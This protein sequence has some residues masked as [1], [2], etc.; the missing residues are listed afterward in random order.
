MKQAR[1]SFQPQLMRSAALFARVILVLG[2]LFSCSGQET[3][4]K[5]LRQR[6][7]SYV[8]NGSLDAEQVNKMGGTPEFRYLNR[9]DQWTQLNNVSWNSQ[10]GEFRFV[11]TADE[12]RPSPEVESAPQPGLKEILSFGK[13]TEQQSGRVPAVAV[14][15]LGVITRSTN[16]DGPLS[17][18]LSAQSSIEISLERQIS[19]NQVMDL[20][21]MELV[22]ARSLKLSLQ[23]HTGQE[24]TTGSLSP[25]PLSQQLLES[26]LDPWSQ[27]SLAPASFN[28]DDSGIYRV[29][30]LLKEIPEFALYLRT[31]DGCHFI[32][33]SLSIDEI[34]EA[35]TLSFPKC[36]TETKDPL[37][38]SDEKWVADFATDT[39]FR[40]PAPEVKTEFRP[41]PFLYT[42]SRKVNIQLWS[43]N[44]SLLLPFVVEVFS[45]DDT[46]GTPVSQLS[47][48]F[49]Q[50]ELR[51]ELPRAFLNSFGESSATGRFSIRIRRNQ[52]ISTFLLLRGHFQDIEPDV[53]STEILN[54]VSSAEAEGT[55]LL[56]GRDPEILV[57]SPFCE[58]QD[59]SL[60]AARKIG[61]S[62]KPQ[63]DE[64]SIF[65]QH[66]S[67]EGEPL[68][69]PLQSLLKAANLGPGSVGR[70]QTL[71][72]A[73]EDEF[74]SRS[75]DD[76][77]ENRNTRS[78]YLDY[79]IPDL[80]LSPLSFGLAIG[81]TAVGNSSQSTEECIFGY[82]DCRPTLDNPSLATTQWSLRS[83]EMIFRFRSKLDCSTL[84]SE[85]DGPAAEAHAVSSYSLR[86]LTTDP[87]PQPSLDSFTTC[88]SDLVI[89]PMS[90]DSLP[91]SEDEPLLYELFV[92]DPAGHISN[93]Q[94]LEIPPCQNSTSGDTICWLL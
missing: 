42:N 18:I 49:F 14:A 33:P 75:A 35:L 29:E 79:G 62:L 10:T 60:R 55:P 84:Q 3:A 91:A 7:S 21:K 54:I 76:L 63:L 61:L 31:Q 94:T 71:R 32:S 15:T 30:P 37:L 77:V 87:Q 46:S 27:L 51:V 8:V 59:P 2:F 53:S 58:I 67:S 50:S 52:E 83:E 90:E 40:R 92:R 28:A 9:N 78:I 88:G 25:I 56:S 80:Q 19:G 26:Q 34:S 72:F 12:M 81:F 23:D 1:S 70:V 66:C 13:G 5:T 73:L 36:N 69:F 89:S 38:S 24:I 82:P 93:S 45:S 47:F 48:P 17:E 86:R 68:R 65:Y 41:G 64:D 43:L 6:S 20:G 4:K 85:Q 16:T 74:G 57:S 44:E 22:E 39:G 11:L